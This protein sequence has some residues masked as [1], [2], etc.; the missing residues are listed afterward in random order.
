MDGLGLRDIA[1]FNKALLVKQLWRVPKHP[2]SLVSHILRAKISKMES[3]WNQ[4]LE[5]KNHHAYGEV[6]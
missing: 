3:Y 4:K 6:F 5:K 2:K 1:S